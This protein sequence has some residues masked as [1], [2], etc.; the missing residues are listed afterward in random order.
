[1]QDIG[2]PVVKMKPEQILLVARAGSFMYGLSTPES[3]ADYIIVYKEPTEVY[4]LSVLSFS[5][6]WIGFFKLI[7]IKFKVCVLLFLWSIQ[8]AFTSCIHADQLQMNQKAPFWRYT[9]VYT[10]IFNFLFCQLTLINI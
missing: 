7:L 9:N 6:N 2:G 3:D 10:D 1:M 8:I 4:I 5:C